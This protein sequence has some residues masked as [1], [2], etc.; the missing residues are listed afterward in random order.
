MLKNL[1]ANRISLRQARKL[2]A[3]EMA[4]TFNAY[5]REGDGAEELV[6]RLRAG[7]A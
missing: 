6:N 5:R 2:L 3:I 4:L 7:S 1:I